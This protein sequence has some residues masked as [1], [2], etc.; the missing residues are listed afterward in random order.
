RAL[1]QI[2]WWF[3]DP[4]GATYLDWDRVH[5]PVRVYLGGRDRIVPTYAARVFQ[6]LR[7]VQVHVHPASSHMAFDDTAQDHFL[8][9][10][11]STVNEIAS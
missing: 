3:L 1:M 9:W 8:H 6:R 7:D 4:T 11:A 2:A 5:C 10:L